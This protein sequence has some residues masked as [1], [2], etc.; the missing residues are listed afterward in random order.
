ML[1]RG[2]HTHVLNVPRADWHCL[3]RVVPM[4]M[5]RGRY[6][7]F[8]AP[9]CWSGGSLSL[10]TTPFSACTAKHLSLCLPSTI[11]NH[12]ACT[13]Y[14]RHLQDAKL[15]LTQSYPIL[16]QL[17]GCRM[18][19]HR[20]TSGRVAPPGRRVK[21]CCSFSRGGSSCSA[22]LCASGSPSANGRMSV[23]SLLHPHACQLVG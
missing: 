5:L 13:N 22:G 14:T 3:A 21:A 1:C 23:P 2:L 10:T 17:K 18:A 7:F 4:Q 15:T 6:G 8:F 20:L 12:K 11:S 19:L 9:C 16:T